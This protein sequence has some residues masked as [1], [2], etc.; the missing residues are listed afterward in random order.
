MMMRHQTPA[1]HTWRRTGRPQA[2]SDEQQ[3]LKEAASHLAAGLAH[4][5]AQWRSGHVVPTSFL[6]VPRGLG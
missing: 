2:S 4:P 6:I 5:F 3:R 1:P